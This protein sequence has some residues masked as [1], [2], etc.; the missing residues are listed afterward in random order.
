MKYRHI[1]KLGIDVSAFGLGCMRLPMMKNEE[2]KDVVDEKKWVDIIRRCIDGGVNYLDTAYVY[3]GG[4]NE[5][6]VGLALRDG[7]RQKVYLATKLP[8]WDCDSKEYMYKTFEEQLCRLETDYIDFY[9]IH[10][11]TGEKWKK[12]KELGVR[13]FLND[14]KAKGK[15]KYACFSFHDNYDAFETIIKEYPWDMCQLQF[16][17]MDVDNQAGLRGVELAGSMGIPVVIMEGLLGGKLANVPLDVKEHFEK[18]NPDFSPVEWAFRW[19]CNFPQIATVLSGVATMEQAEDNLGIFD[20]CEVGI[21]SQQ[22][23]ETVAGAREIYKKRIKVDCTGCEYCMP[24]PMGV[25]IPKIFAKWNY[26]YMY[27]IKDGSYKKLM[28]D[29]KDST[30]CVGCRACM[31]KCPQSFDIPEKL[32]EAHEY[33]LKQ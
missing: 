11:L 5:K 3:T 8:L 30:Q 2:G 9:L 33:F 27:G 23:L 19:L 22:E 15:I 10:C 12:M 17:Y 13:E 25:E 32:K 16:N 26:S 29:N 31:D 1:E 28:D 14:L 6:Y 7:Y 24:C 20:R 4:L 18:A 21:M